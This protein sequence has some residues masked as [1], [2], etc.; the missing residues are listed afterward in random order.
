[1]DWDDLK[2]AHAIA[3][4]GSLSAAA[5]ALGSTQPTVSRRL[6][7]LE[8]RIGVKLFE[9]EAG[10]LRPG[11]LCDVLLESLDGMEELARAVER[12]IAARDT[13]LQGAIVLTSLAWF[14]DDVLA[15]LLA[16]F[17]ARHRFVSVD[18]VNDPRRFNLSRREADVAVR[19]GE[20]DQ[21]D[22]VERK[23][24]DVAY[25][26]YASAGYLN[27]H[28]RPD[29]AKECAGHNVVSLCPS[30][31]RVVH[32]EWL[33]AIAP[34]ASVVLRSNG[35]QSHVATVEAG[36]AMA[37]LPRVMGDRRPEL[38]RIEAPLPEPSQPV[39]IGVHADLRDTPRIRSL[40]DF[41][42][43]ELKMRAN[44]LNPTQE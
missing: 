23:I 3:R 19:I 33:N 22:L 21:E 41:L 34:R 27:R 28:G 16:R 40:I 6:G 44:E 37:V 29:F 8:K 4:H 10:G 30:P 39:K 5:R 17:C 13:G 7:A 42:V 12:R 43:H 14:G 25:G 2:I 36:D 31:A 11:P 35:L 38:V 15:P 24:A 26:L 18:L 1:M 32:I 9:R 20:F